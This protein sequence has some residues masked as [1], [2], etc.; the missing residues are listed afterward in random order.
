MYCQYILT[1][2]MGVPVTAY[3]TSCS[4]CMQT[5][6]SD[7]C[8]FRWSFISYHGTYGV[9]YFMIGLI[10]MMSCACCHN[11][12][13]NGLLT[14]QKMP[15]RPHRLH[16]DPMRIHYLNQCWYVN[17]CNTEKI[18]SDTFEPKTA[19]CIQDN[20]QNGRHFSQPQSV[21]D[22]GFVY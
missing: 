21:K 2:A 1:A 18:F 16:I 15:P 14:N 10:S 17:Y 4:S 22:H 6:R 13:F 3:L 19:V 8:P 7:N 20:L 11:P 12:S 5:V 9:I